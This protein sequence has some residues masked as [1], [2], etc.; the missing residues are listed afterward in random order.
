[1]KIVI[2]TCVVCV[3]LLA[4]GGCAQRQ[5]CPIKE[6]EGKAHPQI[7][8]AGDKTGPSFSQS[9]GWRASTGSNSANVLRLIVR[10][11]GGDGPVYKVYSSQRKIGY[12]WIPSPRG[13]MAV[14]NDYVCHHVTRVILFDPQRDQI[15]DLDSD[16]IEHF[17]RDIDLFHHQ[18]ALAV[19]RSR[20]GGEVLLHLWAKNRFRHVERYYV[21]ETRTGRVLETYE[22]R[23]DVPRTW[24]WDP[25]PD[26][27]AENSV[28]VPDYETP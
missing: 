25:I 1:M 23:Q 12:F 4:A 15:M 24:W 5:P 22:T 14:V 26:D 21:V 13:D 16:A 8:R 19:A 27:F 3:G 11:P 28:E 7:A 17:Q 18:Y 9:E 2:A 6:I 20:T 10:Q